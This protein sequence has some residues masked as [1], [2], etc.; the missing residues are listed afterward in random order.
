MLRQKLN[1]AAIYWFAESSAAARLKGRGNPERTNFL[2][3]TLRGI[4]EEA[5]GRPAAARPTMRK[6]YPDGERDWRNDS[7]FVRFVRRA[8]ATLNYQ[9]SG[10]ALYDLERNKKPTK[11][12]RAKGH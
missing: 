1:V 2:W 11:K 3:K 10:G 6:K 8:L 4:F 5:F 9:I 12:K 7:P